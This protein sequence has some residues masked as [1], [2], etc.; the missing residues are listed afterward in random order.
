MPTFG[1]LFAGIGGIDLGLERAGWECRWQVEINPFC[2]AVLARHWPD[3]P[4]FGDVREVAEL[5]R[6]DLIA[7]GFPCQS[8]S[9]AGRRLGTADERW[10]WP[11]FERV[12]RLVR[13]VLVL[14]ENV[15]GLLHRGMGEVLG[16]LASLGYDAEWDRIPA[17]AVGA[18][19]LRNRIWI[20]AYRQGDAPRPDSY[21][22]RLYR[23]ATDKAG[24]GS[25]VQPRDEQ[26]R[27][28]GS[29]GTAVANANSEG[30]QGRYFGGECTRECVVGTGRLPDTRG[31][32]PE[33]DVGRVVTRL[34]SRMDGGRLNGDAPEGG[35]GQILRAL[36]RADAEDTL[37]WT[38]RGHGGVPSPTLLL[39]AMREQTRSPETLGH[40]SLAGSATSP[41]IMRGVWIDRTLACPSCRWATSEQRPNESS[42]AVRVLSQLLACN[43][44][45]TW[46]DGAGTAPGDRVNRLRALGNAVVPQ[47]AEWIGRRL[48]TNSVRW[49]G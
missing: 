20:V 49:E 35:T 47:V 1:S 8:I 25:E 39:P 9:H 7:G 32:E 38:P 17:A 30:S 23:E 43:C 36:R 5:E 13:P 26:S 2:Q 42:N 22:E 24:Q 28:A 40:L 6:V 37:Q 33:P 45:A 29:V 44:G 21:G 12:L 19:H 3:V 46:V 41:V 11:E 48:M 16:G 14:V 15:P 4:K 18:P 34:S 27:V 10:L 31:W